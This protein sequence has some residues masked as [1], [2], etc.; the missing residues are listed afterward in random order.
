MKSVDSSKFS[1]RDTPY[2]KENQTDE[3]PFLSG[4]FSV[5][6]FLTQKCS[7][8]EQGYVAISDQLYPPPD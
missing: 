6:I 7:D 3:K 2:Y 5:V 8:A 1:S 4:F